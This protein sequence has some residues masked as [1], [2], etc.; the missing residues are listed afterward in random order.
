KIL[1]LSPQCPI[2]T[3]SPVVDL[4]VVETPSS[5]RWLSARIGAGD[6]LSSAALAAIAAHAG[7]LAATTLV[8]TAQDSQREAARRDA[9]F[10]MGQLRVRETGRELESLM[11][12]DRSA[13]MRQHAAFSLSQSDAANRDE[14]LIRQ[15]R[16]DRAAQVRVQAWFWLAQTGSAD[17]EAVIGRAL[18]EDPNKDVREEA[19]FALS[20]LPGDRAVTSLIAI[21]E[22]RE[23]PRAVRERALFWLAQSDSDVAYEK[24]QQLLALERRGTS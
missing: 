23:L 24:I 9:I 13:D 1:T 21:L 16:E 11:F 18:V 6:D 4:G 8:K 3:S 2:V 22:N 14:L 7:D 17:A 10:W 19:V 20:Q 12:T 5:V 15:G